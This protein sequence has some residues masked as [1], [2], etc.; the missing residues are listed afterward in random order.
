MFEAASVELPAVG[1]FLISTSFF[2]NVFFN[3]TF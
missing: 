2:V 1:K 3:N